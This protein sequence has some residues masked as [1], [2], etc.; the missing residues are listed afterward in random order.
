[1]VVTD[2]RGRKRTQVAAPRNNGYI[3]QHCNSPLVCLGLGGNHDISYVD[4]RNG[5]SEYVAK[6]S[7]KADQPDSKV[8]KNVICRTLSKFGIEFNDARRVDQAKLKVTLD[9]VIGAQQIG[10]I[11]ACSYLLDIPFVET[12]LKTVTVN[13]QKE[14]VVKSIIMKRGSLLQLDEELGED[15]ETSAFNTSPSTTLGKREAYHQLCKLYQQQATAAGVEEDHDLE[16][17]TFFAFLSIYSVRS[18]SEKKPLGP[19]SKIENG[20]CP[21]M[22]TDADGFIISPKTFIY[23]GIYY[24]AHKKKAILRL[25]PNIPVNEN[26]ERSAYSTLLLYSN[27]GAKGMDSILLD[28]D[29]ITILTAVEKLQRI[30]ST[31]PEYVMKSLARTAHSEAMLANT[32][33]VDDQKPLDFDA[34]M[35][36]RC[37]VDAGAEEPGEDGEFELD[38]NTGR[39]K[40]YANIEAQR[41]DSLDDD[42]TAASTN[43]TMYETRPEKMKGLLEFVADQDKLRREQIQKTRLTKE[44]IDYLAANNKGR[45]QKIIIKS[46]RH[47]E[48]A[49]EL[50]TKLA[51]L[52]A[53]QLDA[54]NVAKEWFDASDDEDLASTS[55]SFYCGTTS[56]TSSISFKSNISCNPNV[57]AVPEPKPGQLI[58]LLSGQGGT[59]KSRVVECLKLYAITKYGKTEGS[60]G[61]IVLCGPTGNSS[62]NIGG[63]TWQSTLGKGLIT[64]KNQKLSSD[65][66]KNLQ[67]KGKGCKCFVLDEVS[68]LG[69][70]DITDIHTRLCAAMGVDPGEFL[71][72]GL[73]VIFSGDFFQLK[74][75]GGTPIPYTL[76]HHYEGNSASIEGR[77][78]WEKVNVFRELQL[79]FRAG[80]TS[81]DGGIKDLT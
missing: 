52:T 4:N 58:M 19:N 13:T 56:F 70:E 9:V 15:M 11:H 26:D 43:L 77:K 73:N 63:S 35:E 42:D 39:V 38:G 55:S 29:G 5:A 21:P 40:P 44:Q 79:N 14:V 53:E 78:I 22:K 47:D 31:L 76:R 30:K 24:E 12:P 32:G 28:V 72:G 57:T 37:D 71:F 3:N 27:W 8:M 50:V 74:C 59:G 41:M 45:Q 17:L 7:S 66:I 69:C 75:M 81:T 16:K 18:Y 34:M 61:P 64:K 67:G 51:S 60:W 6:Y 33:K 20:I 48:Y 80:G 25:A 10:P 49:A 54:Y 23:K 36:D 68:L 65:T 46:D 2:H 1:M 62:F